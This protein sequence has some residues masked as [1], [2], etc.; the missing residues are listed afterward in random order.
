M[1]NYKYFIVNIINKKM[2]EEI[3]KMTDDQMCIKLI[4]NKTN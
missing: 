3:T 4:A 1:N 2:K